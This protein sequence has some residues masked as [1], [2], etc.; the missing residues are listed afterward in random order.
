MTQNTNQIPFSFF[1]HFT[2]LEKSR[3]NPLPV[4]TFLDKNTM[5][6]DYLKTGSMKMLIV[7]RLIKE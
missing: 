6:I 1:K 5:I 4:S 7:N 2:E 3:I